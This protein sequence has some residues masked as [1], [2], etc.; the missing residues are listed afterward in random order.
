MASLLTTLLAIPLAILSVYAGQ[1]S[2]IA[3]NSL[4]SDKDR[5]ERAAKYS[6]KA[7][8]ELWRTRLTQ[9]SG[10]ATVLFSLISSFAIIFLST[11]S[12]LLS[13]FNV[14]AS[15]AAYMYIS[16]FWKAKAE[17]PFI[18]REYN[19]AIRKSNDLRR[20]LVALGIG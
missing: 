5:A 2:Y 14:A 17:V 18:A 20:L 13:I 19:E 11:A 1:K 15:A 16:G 10:A 8:R 12:G 4:S 7:A 9:A 6:D 3:I